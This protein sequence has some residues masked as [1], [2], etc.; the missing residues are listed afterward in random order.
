MN[1]QE[2]LRGGGYANSL[3]LSPGTARPGAY[4]TTV[5]LP[6]TMRGM[7][8]RPQI[9]P[10]TYLDERYTMYGNNGNLGNGDVRHARPPQGYAETV[11]ANSFVG[12]NNQAWSH[13]SGANT[14][15]GAIEGGRSRNAGRPNLPT[16]GNR[17]FLLTAEP[18]PRPF[19]TVTVQA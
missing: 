2:Y 8:Q 13:N 3:N 1:S 4:N 16:V 17:V 10:S 6:G 9:D 18:P 19:D 5:G 15:N 11:H 7:N 14:I 12:A